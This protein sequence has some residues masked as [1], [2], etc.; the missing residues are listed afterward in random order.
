MRYFFF[1]Y[2]G[3]SFPIAEK[4]QREGH[5]V[6]VGQVEDRRDIHADRE[7]NLAKEEAPARDRRL[8]LYDGIVAKEPAEKLIARLERM[9]QTDRCFVFFDRN[10]LFKFAER[11]RAAG[12]RGNFSTEE[13]H[14]FELDRDEAKRFVRKHYGKLQVA[15]VKECSTVREASEFLA[16][17]E[18]L[19]VLKGKGEGAKTFIPDVD[20]PALAAKQIMQTLEASRALYEQAGFILE[21]MIS[22][23]VEL[24][25]ERIYYDGVPI[26]TTVDVENKPFGSGNVSIQT[27]CA[28]DLVFPIAMKDRINEI[29]FPPVVDE[30]AKKRRG[31][32]Y[33]DA[34]LLIDRRTRKIF[35]GEFCS[36]RPGYNCIFTEIAQC[37]SAHQYF[38]SIAD[39]KSPFELGTVGASVSLFNPATDK[40]D[41][42]RPPAGV[43]IEWKESVEK[44]LWLWD[45]KKEGS[46]IV[47]AGNDWNLGV[48][49]GAGKSIEDAVNRMYKHVD[50]FSFVG[51]YFRPKFDYLSLEYPT[52]IPNRLNYGLDRG[53][54]QLPFNVRVGEVKQ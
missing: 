2:S 12:F 19:W 10:F 1:T 49:T 35:F 8:S 44:D 26:A 51:T 52:S 23:V 31:L 30:L 14:L 7:Q 28:Q 46:R 9:K 11:I 21:L 53:L 16:H 54:Y 50:D 13:D 6:I 3:D 42:C 24:T 18:E 43:P 20:D 15:D 45:A 39:G 4:L 32:F 47:S 36:N 38:S 5:D 37:R 33:W 22:K 27:G 41:R 29:A 25:P 17:T 48:M 34:S 40:D